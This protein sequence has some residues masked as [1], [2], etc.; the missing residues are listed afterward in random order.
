METENTHFLFLSLHITNTAWLTNLHANIV[1]KYET[2][3]SI[4]IIKH[5]KYYY[6][7]MLNYWNITFKIQEGTSSKYCINILHLSGLAD[8]K[9]LGIEVIWNIYI[10]HF[11]IR[12]RNGKIFL[13]KF[14]FKMQN[15]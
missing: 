14:R 4:L 1:L 7:V 3:K 5:K 9:C 10:I 6:Y 12:P 15:N 8:K 11:V 2:K 13:L